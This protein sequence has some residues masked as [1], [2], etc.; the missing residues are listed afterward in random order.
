MDAED[1][2]E[3]ANYMKLVGQG[4]AVYDMLLDI[5]RGTT[6]P[7]ITS[8]ALSVIRASKGDKKKVVAELGVLLNERKTMSGDTNEAMLVNLVRAIADM[9]EA[10]D[11]QLLEPILEHSGGYV[12]WACNSGMEKLAA[13]AVASDASA[14]EEHTEQPDEGSVAEAPTPSP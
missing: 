1:D 10:S 5:V 9:G 11:R 12:R 3:I 14:V 7:I 6:D 2:N 4:E 13:K 8:S